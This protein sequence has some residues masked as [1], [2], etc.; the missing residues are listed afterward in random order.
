MYTFCKLI[1]N[2]ELTIVCTHGWL[3]FVSLSIMITLHFSLHHDY[4]FFFSPSRRE[5]WSVINRG[6]PRW[7]LTCTY[8][9]HDIYF[10]KNTLVGKL[11]YFYTLLCQRQSITDVWVKKNWIQIPKMSTDQSSIILD[12][13]PITNDHTLNSNHLTIM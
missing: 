1:F 2:R 6:F 4:A 9:I 3:R 12:H 7:E 5:K 8:N 10:L 13:L 11:L